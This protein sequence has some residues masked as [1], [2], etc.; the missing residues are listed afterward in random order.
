MST[1]TTLDGRTIPIRD[2]TTTHI[3]NAMY[4][5]CKHGYLNYPH[6]LK[7]WTLRETESLWRKIKRQI[8]RAWHGWY[9]KT[10]KIQSPFYKPTF[11][12]LTE[13]I[14]DEMELP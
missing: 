13:D 9:K 12:H 4:Y 2:M 8:R 1:W 5:L 6:L 11:E 10:P 3:G 7:E 14:L